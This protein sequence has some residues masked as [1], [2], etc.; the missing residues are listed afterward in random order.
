MLIRDFQQIPDLQFNIGLL[1][2]EP[3]IVA[4]RLDFDCTPVG[5]FL[6]L[7]INGRKIQFSENVFYEFADKKISKVWSVLDKAAIETQL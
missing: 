7:P 4:S 2:V 5:D 3:P 6:G 1:V